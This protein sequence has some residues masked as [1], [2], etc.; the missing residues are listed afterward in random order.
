[1]KVYHEK[2]CNS[3]SCIIYEKDNTSAKVKFGL[4]MGFSKNQYNFGGQLI[5]NYG[6]NYQIGAALKVSNIFMFNSHINLKANF[7]FGKDSKSYTLSLP[8]GVEFCHVTY[9]D[10]F[11][12]LIDLR[13]LGNQ[14]A[15]LPDMKAD[16]DVIDLKIPI[17]LNYD[18]NIAEKSILTCG[19]GISNKII[20]SQNKN[21]RVVDFYANYGKSI[22]SLL[23]GIIA[24]TGIEGNWLGKHTFF[25]NVNYEH[26]IDF[27]SEIDNTLKLLNNQFSLQIGMY[28]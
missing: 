7:I 22:N 1:M 25:V 13:Y 3:E 26:L 4:L 8:S 5:S 21:F 19:I 27:R 6:N 14:S 10:V 2:V 11:Y 20:L 28:F 9:N 16:L 12:N 24:T 15:Y 18:F 23:T 17:T